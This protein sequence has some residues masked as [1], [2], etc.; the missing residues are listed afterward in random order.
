MFCEGKN[1]KETEECISLFCGREIT[2]VCGKLA[3][4]S[5]AS[6]R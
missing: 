1:L 3:L 2:G 5:Q 4:T 6:L